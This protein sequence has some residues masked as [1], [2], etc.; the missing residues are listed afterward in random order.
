MSQSF[1]LSKRRLQKPEPF[2]NLTHSGPV[3]TTHMWSMKWTMTFL[4]PS[5][6]DTAGAAGKGREVPTG[7]LFYLAPQLPTPPFGAGI[8]WLANPSPTCLLSHNQI[9]VAHA[10]DCRPMPDLVLF[11]GATF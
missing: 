2:P 3:W 8:H 1:S 10:Q 6:L 7:H 11:N 9:K 5:T 4:F